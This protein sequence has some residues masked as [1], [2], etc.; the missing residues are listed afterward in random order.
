MGR[1]ITWIYKDEVLGVQDT[2]DVLRVFL[3][4]RYPCV[5]WTRKS[6]LYGATVYAARQLRPHAGSLE[7][8]D[9]GSYQDVPDR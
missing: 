4:D 5:P 7:R 9:R 2:N 8:Q 6:N 3:V 1:V